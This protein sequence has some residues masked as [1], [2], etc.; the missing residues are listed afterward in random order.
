MKFLAALG[1]ELKKCVCVIFLP[2]R[3][4]KYCFLK[5]VDEKVADWFLSL[6]GNTIIIAKIKLAWL[7]NNIFYKSF[8]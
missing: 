6:C 3:H 1:F 8:F 4:L 7:R 2:E 5:T